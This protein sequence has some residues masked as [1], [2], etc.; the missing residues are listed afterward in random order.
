MISDKHKS[1]FGSIK[2]PVGLALIAFAI[3]SLITS[4]FLNHIG[5]TQLF[6]DHVSGQGATLGPIHIAQDGTT[7]AVAV[8]QPLPT[9][10]WSFLTFSLLDENKR[11]LTGFGDGLWDETGVDGGYSWHEADETFSAKITVP[12]D[13]T[14]YLALKPES[15]LPAQKL[16]QHSIFVTVTAQ[17]YSP[18]PHLA[19]GI[20]ALIVGVLLNLSGGGLLVRALRES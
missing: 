11:Y 20:I 6:K 3:V 13:G 14:Y 12:D 18:I 15:S 4:F 9:N 17:S 10:S 19:A 5:T 16:A 7:L 1:L 8:R 2:G